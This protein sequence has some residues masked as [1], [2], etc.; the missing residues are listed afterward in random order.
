MRFSTCKTTSN[1]AFASPPKRWGSRCV[2]C[3][4]EDVEAALGKRLRRESRAG[5]AGGPAM[6]RLTSGWRGRK[7]ELGVNCYRVEIGGRAC[8][9][10][11]RGAAQLGQLGIML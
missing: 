2:R 7:L 5:L 3:A 1:S 6:L 9:W 8:G 10:R 11:Y 4:D